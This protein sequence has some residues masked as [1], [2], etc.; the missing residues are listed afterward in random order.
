MLLQVGAEQATRTDA[1]LGITR[2]AAEEGL[3]VMQTV[4]AN[5]RRSPA[6]V[7]SLAAAGIPVRLVKGAFVEAGEIALPWGSETDHA[8]VALAERL[9]ALG[10]PHA[11]ATHDQDILAHLLP[12]DPESTVE[13]LLGVRQDDARRLAASGR[14]VRVYVPYGER[15]FR[16]AARRAAESIGV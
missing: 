2:A 6:D 8:Y 9:A 14:T 11:L 16:Y 7:E 3:P 1:I 15:W 5:L 4:Q 12:L 10:A 13:C